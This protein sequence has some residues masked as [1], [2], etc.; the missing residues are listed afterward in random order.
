[1][2]GCS[3]HDNSYGGDGDAQGFGAGAW[4]NS[5]LPHWS[6]DEDAVTPTKPFSGTWQSCFLPERVDL[7]SMSMAMSMAMAMAMASR[8]PRAHTNTQYAYYIVKTAIGGTCIQSPGML[9]SP[10]QNLDW[11]P[12]VLRAVHHSTALGYEGTSIRYD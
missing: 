3:C 6:R 2:P 8:E 9:M 10:T 1:M 12:R 4:S 5:E 7:M 11:A